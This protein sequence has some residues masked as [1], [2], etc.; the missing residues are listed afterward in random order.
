MSRE[1]KN[2]LA[3]SIWRM[4]GLIAVLLFLAVV[5]KGALLIKDDFK[6]V[7]SSPTAKGQAVEI[8]EIEQPSVSFFAIGIEE[9]GEE[10]PG[11]EPDAPEQSEDEK[12]SI[13]D[14]VDKKGE[15]IANIITSETGIAVSGGAVLVVLALIFILR[16]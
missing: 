4:I 11:E 12:T 8:V 1:P 10:T 2:N 7:I 13:G 16:K 6:E 5:I 14:Y 9:P 15:E 3:D